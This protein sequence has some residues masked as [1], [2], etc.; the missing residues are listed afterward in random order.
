MSDQT[1][2]EQINES[3]R[4]GLAL[5][6]GRQFDEAISEYERMITLT[7]E[8][9]TEIQSEGLTIDDFLSIA[10]ADIGYCHRQ[11]NNRQLAGE[12]VDLALTLA[13]QGVSLSAKG[14]AHEEQG[15]ILRLMD[16][17]HTEALENTKNAI[18]Y[19]ETALDP[20]KLPLEGKIYTEEELTNR[21]LRTY[22]LIST[23]LRDVSRV[24]T[25]KEKDE[26]L[27]QADK[28]G[29]KAVDKRKEL[30]HRNVNSHHSLAN[31]KN[32]R[33]ISSTGK[34]R[35]QLY[36]A[37][38]MHTETAIEYAK[39][40]D[41]AERDN[42]IANIN[43]ARFVTERNYDLRSNATID[44]F[45]TFLSTIQYLSAADAREFRD[46]QGLYADAE[47]LGYL[48]KT[49]RLIEPIIASKE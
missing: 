4:K 25:P 18:D 34:E 23:N 16:Y 43:Y 11:Q 9:Q 27:K 31:V 42:N 37:A 35:E 6:E 40:M 2:V 10:N 33:L 24:A 30:G 46:D 48:D 19:Y 14:R 47:T 22:G 7:T 13:S 1:L 44:T 29:T 8:A 41:P 5:V 39:D 12:N 20:D 21:L 26:L 32:D 49:K 45:K 38:R 36:N 3:R 15:L 17:N 28:Y